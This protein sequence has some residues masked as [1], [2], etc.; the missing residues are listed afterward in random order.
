MLISDCVSCFYPDVVDVTEASRMCRADRLRQLHSKKCHTGAIR[1][2]RFC[3]YLFAELLQPL[4]VSFAGHRNRQA[5][6]DFVVS[7]DDEDSAATPTRVASAR[8]QPPVRHFTPAA[9]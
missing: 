7:S 8:E 9:N 1:K 6:S 3:L 2:G 4:L 5:K